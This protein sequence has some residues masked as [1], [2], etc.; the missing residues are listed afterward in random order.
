MSIRPVDYQILMPKVNELARVQNEDQQKLVGHMLQQADS[1][2][3]Q[4]DHDT[5]SVYAQKEAQKPVIADKQKGRNANSGKR[6][7]KEKEPEEEAGAKP[8]GTKLQQRRT[9]DIRL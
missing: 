7:K 1:S 5:E 3:K 6:E 8:S 9:I 2:V 4:A